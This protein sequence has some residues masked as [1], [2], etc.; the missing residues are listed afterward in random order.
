MLLALSTAVQA[1]GAEVGLVHRQ[2]ADLAA[3]ITTFGHG[4]GTELLLGERLMD[5]DPTLA[6]A[7]SGCTIMAEP[8][9]GEAGRYM[10]GRIGRC[11]PAPR[12]LAMVPMSAH[13]ALTAVFEAGRRLR[14]FNAREVSRME[15]V[16]STLIERSVVMGWLDGAA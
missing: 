13:G 6:A 10:A 15:D 7:R 14:P 16:I 2:R 1:M 3:V 9:P 4:A 12:G 5:Q 11:I 8:T